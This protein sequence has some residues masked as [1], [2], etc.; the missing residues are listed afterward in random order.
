[1]DA[2]I[3]E[4]SKGLTLILSIESF[5]IL[6]ISSD[7][8][9]YPVGYQLCT[10]TKYHRYYRHDSIIPMRCYWQSVWHIFLAK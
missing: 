3:S 10:I 1:M 7:V 4:S 6:Q 8:T 9:Q 5:F 2:I